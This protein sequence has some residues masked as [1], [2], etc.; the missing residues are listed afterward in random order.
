MRTR[1]GIFCDKVIEAGW[2][3][4]VIVVPLFFNIYSQRVFEPDKITL[5]RSI[6]LVMSAA[7]I[8]RTAEDW[9]LR[10]AEGAEPSER[11]P[12]G[13]K[14]I[15][16]PLVLPTLFFVVIY[17][18]STVT[19]VVPRTSLWGSHV[20]LQG[21]YSILAY[22]V[23]FFLMLDGLRTKKQLGRL[24]TV[25]ILASFPIALY[26]LVQHFGL[27]P[28]PWGGDVT[29]RVTSSM[30]NAVF[31]A[32][33]LI[34][35]IP[36]TLTRLLENWKEAI[37]DFEAADG[38]LGLV[39][40]V[41]LAG[42]LLGAMLLGRNGSAPGLSWVML[43]GGAVI[44]AAVCVLRPA[45]RRQQ[46]LAISMPLTFAFLVG[47]VWVLEIPFPPANSI[48]FGWGVLASAVFLL[49][50]VPFAF[51]LRRPV[52]RLLLLAAY[53]VIF[54]AQF[55]A[56]FYSQSRGPQVGLLGGMLFYL[57]LLGLIKKRV[58]VSWLMTGLAAVAIVA[59]LIFNLV[60]S[61]LTES[62]RKRPTWGDSARSFRPK[63]ARAKSAS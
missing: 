34:M 25:L 53:F 7:W 63:P 19:S 44:S 10:K 28:L 6:A 56:I 45:E 27:D 39:S 1:L 49:A 18:I 4:A 55:V 43:L 5:L 52:S 29:R 54:I 26:G 57:V 8:I 15:K 37:G 9:R 41:V 40:F 51:Y 61:P 16:A 48:Y 13:Q 22:I 20:R 30:G 35:L 42:A 11:L 12:L 50:M 17:V 23:I 47:F 24:I 32:A 62:L 36:L 14:I 46:V 38:I 21:T 59:M 3:A 58:W 33:Y 2:L 60:D 31:V